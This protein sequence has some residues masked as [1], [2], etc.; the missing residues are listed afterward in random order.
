MD[1]KTLFFEK[2]KELTGKN[3]KEIHKIFLESKMEKHS[4]IRTLFINELGLTYGYAN[5]LAHYI[6]QTD[7][8]S[9]SEGKSI[10]EILD[11]IYSGEKQRFRPI[12]EAIMKKIEEFGQFEVIPKKGYVS[13]KRKKQFAMIGPKTNTRMEIGINLKSNIVDQRLEEQPSGSM[14]QYIYKIKDINDLDDQLFEWLF[15]AYQQSE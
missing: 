10:H 4:E 15:S 11:E 7:G 8:A 3:Q 13:F 6:A 2:M 12:H 5:T 9:L 14:C 1:E